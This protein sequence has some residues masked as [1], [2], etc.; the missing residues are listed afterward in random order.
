MNII[1]KTELKDIIRQREMLGSEA[2]LYTC[3]FDNK[4]L[5]YKEPYEFTE[6]QINTLEKIS[7]IKNKK[8]TLPMYLVHDKNKFSGYLTEYLYNYLSI[9]YLRDI[10]LKKKIMILKRAKDAI[11]SM[12]S[13]N[14][15]HLDL[16]LANI[17]CKG[18]KIK[19]I[20]FDD[21]VYNYNYKPSLLNS[22]ARSYLKQNDLNYSIDIFIFNITTLSLIFNIPFYDIL[23]SSTES[24]IDDMLSGEKREIWQKTKEKR[25]LENTDFLIDYY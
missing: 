18:T 25:K 15:I 24:K 2:D 16:S 20:D 23:K 21:S 4:I 10:N 12:H 1:K 6:E 13:K 8:L 22:Y 7:C 19:I 14:I 5:V 17:M 9:F 3:I 11:L